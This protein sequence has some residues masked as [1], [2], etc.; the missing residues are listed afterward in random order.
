M[1]ISPNAIPDVVVRR[2]PIYARSLSYLAEE[3][4][5]SV[6]SQELGERIGVT[7]A[8]IRKDLSYFGEFGKQGIG[9]NVEYLLGHIRR[10]LGLHEVW[11]VVLVG[12]GPL[13][14]AIARYEG[15]RSRGID[16]IGVFDNDA[17][18]IG[19]Q[20]GRNSVQPDSDL[21]KILKEHGIRLAIVA[22][23]AV[24]A[25]EVV[26]V[27]VENGVQ[28]ILNYAPVVVQTP[29]NVWVRHIDPVALLH[30][31]TYYLSREDEHHAMNE[32]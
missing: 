12:V 1:D 29:E 21:P 25:Q 15:F 17:S 23:P 28:G 10:I 16:I 14:Q 18:K 4:V 5:R 13:G 7:A 30:S 26:D 22:V 9:Y 31:M 6:S 32:H 20:L 3:G 24:R 8:Q 11:P 19:L 27:L 2:L